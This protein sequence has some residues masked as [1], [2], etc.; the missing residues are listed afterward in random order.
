MRTVISIVCAA[1]ILGFY[2][3]DESATKPKY[4]DGKDSKPSSSSTRKSDEA[5]PVPSGKAEFPVVKLETSE[6]DILIELNRK[7]APVTVENFLDYCRTGF[8][9]GTIFHRV[10]KTFMIQGGGMQDNGVQ[11]T[12]KKAIQNE[13]DNGLSNVRGTISMARTGDPN[14]AT[15]QFFINVA[16]NSMSLNHRS[17]ASGATW[18]YC[19]FGKVKD[20]ASQVV[21][22]KIKDTPCRQDGMENSHPV[23]NIRINKA[24][25]ISE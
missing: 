10:I 22:D 17:K 20:D 6:G 9:E 21:V 25:I 19:V 1:F 13:A 5:P 7:K 12:T 24:T 8:Y 18:G 23:K 11:K 15:S 16:D 2:G 14:S 4:Q 3:C